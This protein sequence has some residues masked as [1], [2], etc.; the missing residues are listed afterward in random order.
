MKQAFRFLGAGN[1]AVEFWTGVELEEAGE[2][3]GRGWEGRG[4][5]RSVQT[6]SRAAGAQQD[7]GVRVQMGRGGGKS[8]WIKS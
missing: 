6:D 7:W 5:Q 4:I 8:G 3:E 1:L 2:G